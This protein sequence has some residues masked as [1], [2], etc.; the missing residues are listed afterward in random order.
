MNYLKRFES[1]SAEQWRDFGLEF[2]EQAGWDRDWKTDLD[3][4]SIDGKRFVA[5]FRHNINLGP[6]GTDIEKDL[7]PRLKRAGADGF[8]GFY[9]GDYTTSLCDRL[10]RL[11]VQVVLVSGVQI[12]VLLPYSRSSFIDRYFGGNTAGLSWTWNY[13]LNKVDPDDYKPLHCMCGC[14]R[15]ILDNGLAIGHSAAFIHRADD[16]LYFIYG[17][18]NCIFAA[19]DE[20]TPCGWVEINQ[21]LHP[22][23]FNIWNG[24]LNSYL[25]DNIDLDLT[26]YHGPKRIFTS[27]ILQRMRSVNAGFFLSGEEF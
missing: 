16:K 13:Y 23:Q 25:S 27:R 24:M 21:I 14:G 1:W 20:N 4:F 11:K 12:S 7:I 2:L 26:E 10:S 3:V 17:L 5:S 9:S 15:D 8:I 6:I 18:K 19:C 22:D